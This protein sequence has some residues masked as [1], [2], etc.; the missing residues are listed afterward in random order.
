LKIGFDRFSLV[1]F[2][3]AL[4]LIRVYDFVWIQTEHQPEINYTLEE[5]LPEYCH[6]LEFQYRNVHLRDSR[7]T[8]C[9]V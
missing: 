7:A 8:C 6:L 3:G 1:F 5:R 2:E 4:T 9:E